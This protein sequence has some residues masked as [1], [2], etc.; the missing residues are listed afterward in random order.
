MPTAVAD[1][2]QPGYEVNLAI[3]PNPVRDTGRIRF[4]LAHDGAVLVTLL[5]VQGRERARLADGQY[6]AGRVEL[7]LETRGL[8]PGL[9]W[10]RVEAAGQTEKRTVVILK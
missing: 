2:P 9:Y 8:E 6:R 4:E 7:G 3:T 1:R 5:D 10:C